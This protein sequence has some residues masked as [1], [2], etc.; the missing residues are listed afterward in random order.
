MKHLLRTLV[1]S[2][3]PV[4]LGAQVLDD[5]TLTGDYH[6][7]QILVSANLAGTVTNVRNLSGTFTFDGNGGVA[8][9]GQLGSAG[10]APTASAGAGIY[11]VEPNGFILMTNPIDEALEINARVGAGLEVF[12]GSSTESVDGSYDLLM[13]I[14]APTSVDNSVVSGAYTGGTLSFPGGTASELSTALVRFDADGAGGFTTMSARG[15]AINA[16]E[17]NEEQAIAG[18]TYSVAADGTG[19][20]ALGAGASLF[21]GN[22]D[23]FVSANGN[24]MLGT[25]SET[26][27]R[28]IFI[29]SRNLGTAASNQDW[30]GNYWFA[31]IILDP[32]FSSL[33]SA[34]GGLATFG[35][36]VATIS[37]RLLLNRFS[38]DFSSVNNYAINANSTGQLAPTLE[39]D[40]INMGLGA[41]SGFGAKGAASVPLAA[42]G[43]QV[44]GLTTTSFF[45]GIFIAI[46]MPDLTGDGVFLN[47]LGVLNGASFAP[48]TYPISAGTIVSL[49]GTGMAPPGTSTNAGAI[50]L[51]TA[52]SGVSVTIDGVPAPLFFVSPVQINAQVPFATV[53]DEYSLG[54]SAVIV[55]T[56]GGV[57]SNAVS[58]PLGQTSPGV[59]S[60]NFNGLGAG[61]IVDSLTFQPISAD[62]PASEGQF[63]SIFLTGLGDVKPPVA[64]GTAAPGVEPLAR[65]TDPNIWV[66]FSVDALPGTILY[67]GAAPNF[68][69][70]YQI[71]VQVPSLSIESLGTD[72]PLAIVT[73]NGFSDF[74]T[75][76]IEY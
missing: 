16:G 47:P 57:A 72:V 41:P 42:V 33:T 3:L 43:A 12:I 54:T 49:F 56:N 26:G 34:A 58:V 28:E 1:G 44:N 64:D 23:I 63:V 36:G 51:P 55:V 48:T 38:S 53:R 24:F 5:T 21:G 62:N 32:E 75:I 2:L 39:A 52:L 71:N 10:D 40:A 65:T 14:K 7:V 15:H 76:A 35:T 25:S 70:L 37:E 17:T 27:G 60:V 13:A 22:Q 4:L 19:T 9:T 29:T 61:I 31:E 6:F 69:G 11:S 20:A 68:V 74:V 67:S 66:L 8:F 73:T 59:F 45:H 46:R 18:A 30:S 50:P